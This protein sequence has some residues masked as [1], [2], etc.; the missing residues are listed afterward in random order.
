MRQARSFPVP[1]ASTTKLA[2]SPAI[3]LVVSVA[4]VAWLRITCT[5]RFGTVRGILF[6]DF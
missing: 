1:V 6:K 3:R 5:N 2:R 4:K